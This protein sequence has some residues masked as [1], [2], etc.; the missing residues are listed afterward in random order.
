[1]MYLHV[2]ALSLALGFSQTASAGSVDKEKKIRCD[3]TNPIEENVIVE[4]VTDGDTVRVRAKSGSYSVRMMGIDTPETHFMGKSQGRWGEEAAARSAELMPVGSTIRL[5]LSPEICDGNGRVLAYVFKG[6][7]H[8]NKQ[9]AKEGLAANYCVAPEF[10]YCEE[11]GEAVEE[12]ITEK[13]GFFGDPTAELPYDF[14]RRVGG[15]EQRSHVGN[16]ESKEVY[17]PGNQ[18]KVP[19]E[20]RV[21]FFTPDLVKR[22]YHIVQ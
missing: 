22:P 8:V 7:T 10:S 1:M 13:L 12:A 6:R 21:F 4:S 11:I 9:L 18:N 3:K 17:L 16:L 20:K 14:R 2:L 5:E 19:V 15:K